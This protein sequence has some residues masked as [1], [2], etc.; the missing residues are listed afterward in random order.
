[1]FQ[2]SNL[3]FKF[4]MNTTIYNNNIRTYRTEINNKSCKIT[5]YIMKKLDYNT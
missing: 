5:Y 2:I 1:M 4:I 3:H